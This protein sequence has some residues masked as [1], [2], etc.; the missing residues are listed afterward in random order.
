MGFLNE[1]H[2]VVFC[3]FVQTVTYISLVILEG[4][5]AYYNI[6]YSLCYLNVVLY[7]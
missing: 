4:E 3:C 1:I 6:R 7:N 2:Y 5:R